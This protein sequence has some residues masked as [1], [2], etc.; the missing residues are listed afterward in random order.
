MELITEGVLA[1]QDGEIPSVI[2]ARLNSML[3]SKEQDLG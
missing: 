3:P 2:R 1:I